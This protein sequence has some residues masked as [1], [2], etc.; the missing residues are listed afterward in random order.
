M[1]STRRGRTRPINLVGSKK[2]ADV[3]P[4]KEA[5]IKGQRIGRAYVDGGAQIGVMS[6]QMMN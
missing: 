5:H 2:L 1:V 4:I 3:E 6:E